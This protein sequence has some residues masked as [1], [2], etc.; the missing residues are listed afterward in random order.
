MTKKKKKI[1][2]TEFRKKDH[3]NKCD[4]SICNNNFQNCPYRYDENV[5]KLCVNCEDLN[6]EIVDGMLK[7]YHTCKYK[8][9]KKM[10]K[11]F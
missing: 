4:V 10:D 8:N 1:S 5:V 2:Y 7:C 11:W 3:C 9:Q 6:N